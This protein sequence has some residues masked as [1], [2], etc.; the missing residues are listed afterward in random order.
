MN[1][2]VGALRAAL[3]L[4]RQRK[5][6]LHHL[7]R[8]SATSA[9]SR[10]DRASTAAREGRH[11]AGP[12]RLGKR[13]RHQRETAP[14]HL[15][16]LPE[17]RRPLGEGSPTAACGGST[18]AADGQRAE[19][20]KQVQGAA[21]HDGAPSLAPRPPPTTNG[22]APC[23]S[24]AGMWRRLPRMMAGEGRTRGRKSKRT[25][26]P[27]SWGDVCARWRDTRARAALTI[28]AT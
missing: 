24:P 12:A 11:P 25:G 13:R 2:P 22:A 14:P 6:R 7:R 1:S 9:S 5:K 4:Y 18:T 28:D 3:R 16:R 10:G 26:P 27:M 17:R 20:E 21:V 23:R 8:R 19:G 15:R